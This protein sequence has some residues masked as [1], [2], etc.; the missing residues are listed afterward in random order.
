VEEEKRG[1]SVSI[2]TD[3]FLS[4][5]MLVDILMPFG[6]GRMAHNSRFWRLEKINTRIFRRLEAFPV[7]LF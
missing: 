2:Q 3:C 4:G 5:A 1:N 7:L 6:K